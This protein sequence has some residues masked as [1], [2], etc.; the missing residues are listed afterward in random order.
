MYQHVYDTRMPGGGEIPFEL[1]RWIA[2]APFEEYL[3]MTIEEAAEGHAVLTMPFTVK[4][5][6][7]VGFMHG[8]AITAL[9]DTAVAMAI[10]SVLPEGSNFVTMDLGLKFHA[11]VRSGVVRAVARIIE[12][13]ERNI[14]GEAEVF[15]G[16][17]IKVATFSSV[18]RVRRQ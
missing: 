12:R 16:E 7:G 10:K 6:Q 1:P 2:C 9:A 17:G 11:P 13:D 3:G 14:K 18:F 15:D 5:S 4:L 8:G